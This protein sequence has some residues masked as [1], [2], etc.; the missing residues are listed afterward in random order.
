[1]DASLKNLLPPCFLR[2]TASCL[3]DDFVHFFV[4]FN[5]KTQI[6]QLAI[7]LPTVVTQR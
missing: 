5:K 6:L 7:Q 4:Y 1:M 2:L 3:L